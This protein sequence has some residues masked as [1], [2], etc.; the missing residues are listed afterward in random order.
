METGRN[1]MLAITRSSLMFASLMG[2]AVAHAADGAAPS[3]FTLNGDYWPTVRDRFLRGLDD[4]NLTVGAGLNGPGTLWIV[5][6]C[7]AAESSECPPGSAIDFDEDPGA[8]HG[9]NTGVTVLANDEVGG[10]LG[11]ASVVVGDAGALG[12]VNMYQGGFTISGVNA[13]LSLGRDGGAGNLFV[14]SAVGAGGALVEGGGTGSTVTLQ[15]VDTARLTVGARSQSSLEAGLGRLAIGPGLVTV[16]GNSAL[17]TVG[18]QHNGGSGTSS[19]HVLGFGA[20]MD[21]TGGAGTE[22]V[23]GA[24]LVIG[25]EPGASGLVTV[26]G[27]N[28]RVFDSANGSQIFVA[29]PRG[30]TESDNLEFPGG[31]SGTLSVTGGGF[32]FANSVFVGASAADMG[33][34]EGGTG[35][36]TVSGSGVNS[37]IDSQGN[38]VT[39]ERISSLVTDEL[40]IGAVEDAGG[41]NSSGTVRVLDGGL[42]TESGDAGSL[43]VGSGG[44]LRIAGDGSTVKFSE[45]VVGGGSGVADVRV[46]AGGLLDVAGTLLLG[47]GGVLGGSGGTLQVGTLVVD[48]GTLAPGNSPGTLTI[49]GDLEILSGSLLLEIEGFGAGQFDVLNVT[50][51]ILGSSLVIDLQ[52]ADGLDLSGTALEMLNI[53]DISTLPA[54]SLLVN[55][56]AMPG[57]DLFTNGAGGFALGGVSPYAAPVPLPAAWPLMLA[58]LGA[59]AGLRRRARPR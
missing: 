22:N 44:V 52:V 43:L 17:V 29:A 3:N 23:P 16:V 28:L 32:A 49:D 2:V 12:G 6:L 5:P 8:F 34:G 55:G 53:G 25:E 31:G 39:E 46:D 20:T 58:G 27:G 35:E 57:I 10:T 41:G 4:V 45:V 37:Y 30:L 1:S 59:L 19:L 38:E 50:G 48:G 40:Y 7:S 13:S 11:N 24:R 26:S 51:R 14:G 18:T 47:S 42:L 9:S 33:L 54:L 21:I 56:A 15:A 36:L